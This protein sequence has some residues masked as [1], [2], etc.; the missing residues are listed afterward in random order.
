MPGKRQKV[1]DSS[2]AT[3]DKNLGLNPDLHVT[4]QTPPTF[5]LQAED[6]HVDNV[7]TRWLL[8]CAEEGGV[9]VECI[10]MRTADMRSACGARSSDNG[11]AQLVDMWL[12]TIGMISE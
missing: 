9:P 2:P 5:L 10:C 6:D 1:C 3:A 12:A 7:T 8:Y 11:M 4:S